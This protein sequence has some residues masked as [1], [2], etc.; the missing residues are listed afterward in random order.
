MY[1]NR[2]YFN[3]DRLKP[4]KSM[5]GKFIEKPVSSLS[6]GGGVTQA[7]WSQAQPMSP[8]NVIDNVMLNCDISV[9]I[10]TDTSTYPTANAN[11]FFIKSIA[12]AVF[13]HVAINGGVNYENDGHALA[14]ILECYGDEKFRAFDDL[15]KQD[16]WVYTDL[17]NC[18]LNTSGRGVKITTANTAASFKAHCSIP[19]PHEFLLKQLG[20][21]RSL[22]IRCRFDQ[23]L[24]S[25]LSQPSECVCTFENTTSI[26]FT[27]YTCPGIDGDMDFKI[28]FPHFTFYNQICG[29]GSVTSTTTNVNSTP[30]FV[31]NHITQMGSN[32]SSGTTYL[33]QKPLTIKTATININN[34]GN[35]YNCAGA[36]IYG[37]AL[38][39][40]YHGSYADWYTPIV[41]DAPG[42]SP[43]NS[44]GCVLK[45]EMNYADANI[46]SAELFRYNETDTF[47]TT[48]TFQTNYTNLY[49]YTTYC[50]P[51][52]M[53]LSKT[54]SGY[55][56]VSNEPFADISEYE[57]QDLIVGSGFW[58]TF[59]KFGKKIITNIP[60][61]MD[62]TAR[63]SNV[64][65]PNSGFTKG[66]T[67]ASD[68]TNQI[69]NI[70]QGQA[71]SIF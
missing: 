54:E 66:I 45:V 17:V 14:P 34:V 68:M 49:Q 4:M 8:N 5:K 10:P 2:A 61:I 59:K 51:G 3:D 21:I 70:L 7:F 60:S 65:S 33:L 26:T 18:S 1:S 50:Y 35:A 37:R 69:S 38:C 27:E 42:K 58:D 13:T 9:S 30:A 16:N 47:D 64:I 46:N 24:Y 32:I 22:D 55:E 39:A 57:M 36:G 15:E 40:G 71:T 41:N 53:H 6:S 11:Y 20:G 28:I 62:K 25:I 23:N 43:I 67:K 19:F 29:A 52:I 31:F 63:I 56:Y 48:T 44:R 12:H